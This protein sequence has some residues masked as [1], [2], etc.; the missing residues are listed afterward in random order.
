MIR[1]ALVVL[2]L[3]LGA[4][5][6][7]QSNWARR[8]GSWSNDAYNSI[9]VDQLGNSYVTGEFGGYV[10]L[11]GELIFSQGSLDIVV[12]KYDPS[13]TLVWSRAFGGPGLDKGIALA[14]GQAG[15]LVVVGQ[16]M[17]TVAFG[18]FE[19]ISAGGTQDVFL[20]R[21]NAADGDLLW[22]R[23]GGG[24]NGVDQPN[25]V[26]VAPNGDIAVTGEF[27]GTAVFDGGTLTSIPDPVT[28]EPSVD[29]FI[30]AYSAT[31][32]ALWLKHGAA[33]YAD[34]GMDVVHDAL[35][36]VYVTGQF[37]DTL[38]FDVTHNNAMF[39]AVFI[40]RFDP[41]GN[42]TWFRVFGGGSY[43]QVFDM[44]VVE[45]DRL[46]LVGDMQGTAI[47]LD[48][49]PNFITA[50]APRSSF[51][52][53]MDLSGEFIQ[54]NTWGSEHVLN[55][56]SL[57]I[58]G[59]EVLVLGRFRC[60]FTGFSSLYGAG[61]WLATGQH[62]L[63]VARFQLSD[64]SFKDAQQFGGQK[65]KVPGGI[66]YTLDGAPL[67][68]GSFDRLL[69][70]PGR[71]DEF[72]TTPEINGVSAP[73][74]PAEFCDD[75]NYGAYV[76]LRGSALMDAFIAKGWDEG[77]EPYD[78][79]QRPSGSCDRP[80]RDAFIQ[81]GNQGELGPDSVRIC[82]QAILGVF[83]NTAYTPDTAIRHTAPD[84]LYSWSTGTD[85]VM[86]TVTQSGWYSV[87]VSSAAGCWQRNDSLFVTIDPL[88]AAPLVNDDVVV[89]TNDPTPANIIVCEPVQPWL[90]ATGL[91]PANSVR[92]NGPLG[93]VNG[94]SIQATVSGWYRVTTTT[95]FGCIATVQLFVTISPQ[96]SLPALQAE[97]EVLF[98]QDLDLN[99]TVSIC[100]N[101][102][103]T[104]STSVSL[105]LNGVAAELPYGVRVMRSCDGSPWVFTPP[106][107]PLTA[108]CTRTIGQEGWYAFDIGILL[109]N[110]PCGDDTLTFLRTDSIY[111][112]PFPV[113]DPIIA[114]SGPAFICPGDTITLSMTCVGCDQSVWNGPS[115][116]ENYTDS[117]WVVGP[118]TYSC[119]ATSEDGN[120]CI[121]NDQ[122]SHIVIW[123]PRPL[124]D[125]L[126]EDGI[127]CPDSA[128]VIFSDNEGLSHQWYGPLGPLSVDNDTIITSQQGLYY[129]EMI[130]LLGCPV[131]SDPVLVTDYSTPYLN[132]LPDNAICEVGE[133]ST[134]QVVTTGS[135]SLQWWTPL[136]GNALQQVVDAPGTYTC[137]V[138][139]CGITTILSTVIFG[140]NAIAELVDPG[141]FVLCPGDEV[142]LQAVPGMP[143]YYWLPGQVIGDQLTVN[144][145][146][147]YTLVATDI[148]GCKASTE[149]TVEV[150][151]WTEALTTSDTTVCLGSTVVLNVPGSGTITWYADPDL[152]QMVNTGNV[153]DLGA[154]QASVTFFVQQAEGA[155]V[156]A[157]QQLTVE[158]VAPPVVPI[159]VG[160]DTVCT[161]ALLQLDV[162]A[163]PGTVYTWSTPNGTSTGVPLVIENVGVTDAGLYSV[164]AS[165][166]GCVVTS[167]DLTLVVPVPATLV[168]APDTLICP[169]GTATFEL[170]SGF[171]SP[172]WVDGSSVPVFSTSDEGLV[173]V[174]A[175][176]QN[177]CS[178]QASS[179]VNVFEPTVP[180]VAAPVSICSGSDA[181]LLVQGSGTFL[182]YADMGLSQPVGS[183]NSLVLTSPEDSATY[184]VVQSE[185]VCTGEPLAVPLYVVPVPN[186]LQITEPQEVCIGSPFTVGISGEDQLSG[187][188]TT[189]T[190]TFV[191]ADLYTAEASLADGGSYTV[192]ASIGACSGD[193]LTTTVTVLVPQPLY[194][195]ADTVFCDGSTFAITLPEGFT[196]PV[197]TTGST[198]NVIVVTEAGV[199]T[200][201]AYDAQ[202]CEVFG[203]I[204]LQLI[205]CDLLMPNVMTPNGDGVN[206]VWSLAPGPF[207]SSTMTVF[208]R[209]GSIV[210]EGDPSRNGFRGL[211][212]NTLEPLSDGVYY[213]VLR[214]QRTADRQDEHKG[215]FQLTR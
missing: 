37:S 127:I 60:Q 111:V 162:L 25:G 4:D 12:A 165:N 15:E 204:S 141:P 39:S 97:Y 90:W 44:D 167:V 189:P 180:A 22:A 135:A 211:N 188:W 32:D 13:G 178:V 33:E 185:W 124:L 118:G 57:A 140:N 133:T 56:R 76:G 142:V 40:A 193:T 201:K 102:P 177:G 168:L 36:N 5:A 46:L 10:E 171:S 194:L 3:L 130:D 8:V 153:F 21:M 186:D 66:A 214:L 19:M 156:S 192:A 183:G 163:E 155:C 11:G 34:R 148:N 170:P 149:A 92:W 78:M 212:S 96:G 72:D 43:N 210:W 87:I 119:S 181:I 52:L 208:N 176:D 53:E 106:S 27:R 42:E 17:A 31:G 29:I 26:S 146:G 83:T 137:S 67:F 136:S 38:T 20:L 150:I 79:F 82:R 151:P 173:T 129:L 48:G 138:N 126:P 110:A 169:M 49:A 143:I 190:G 98:P 104:Y 63:Y 195:G 161:G 109:T 199:Y 107:D 115:I 94:D 125:V 205:D 50:A 65:N 24:A 117:I 147:T 58:R 200:V 47:F 112:I 6:N 9:V 84:L 105:F 206:D 61:T 160:P 174:Q 54:A 41:A 209:F 116:V 134:L 71:A 51:L 120:G 93:Q 198:A 122:D 28:A 182:W 99:D 191:G 86:I 101:E 88:P 70:F 132:V 152:T 1:S 7:S 175:V 123:N 113:I 64:L 16:F 45:G 2:L 74:V 91:D 55:T 103:L 100:A 108:S 75:P 35:G 159:I 69:V 14:L 81:L 121:T 215:Y 18:P 157:I 158:V 80:Q 187:T 179:M 196:D 144:A 172:V 145:T 184:Y 62:D 23:Q 207:V 166:V 85:S 114:V 68:C 154:L 197:W 213:F 164:S 139:A 203:A 73:D 30:A 128:A 89:N 59:T 131:T 95:P 77:R 202:G